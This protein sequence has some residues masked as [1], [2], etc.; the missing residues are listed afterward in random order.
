MMNAAVLLDDGWLLLCQSLG[1]VP[2]ALAQ[3]VPEYHNTRCG[4]HLFSRTYD[5]DSLT[6]QD[7]HLLSVV[8][9]PDSLTP[10]GAGSDCLSLAA[11]AVASQ[12]P[13]SSWA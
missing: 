1:D 7:Q 8:P 5:C 13:S 9:D 10:Q 4:L 11:S 2:L 6:V 3:E 12:V